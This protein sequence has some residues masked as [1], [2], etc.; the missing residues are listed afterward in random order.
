[1][2]IHSSYI[3]KLFLSADLSSAC[4][5][6][7]NIFW[8]RN[9]N[10]AKTHRP[11]FN[12]FSCL[13]FCLEFLFHIIGS[14]WRQV[15]SVFLYPSFLNL[16]QFASHLNTPMNGFSYWSL[17]TGRMWERHWQSGGIVWS[18]RKEELLLW[19]TSSLLMTFQILCP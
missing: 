19:N 18:P 8:N 3:F 7:Q 4:E 12:C 9:K 1:M 11:F 15:S 16:S 5:H 13:R 17:I 2:E 10:Q 6:T 14:L